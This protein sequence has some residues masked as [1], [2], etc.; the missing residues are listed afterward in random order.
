MSKNQ[1]I[2]GDFE[3]AYEPEPTQSVF[4]KKGGT[5]EQFKAGA[6][7]ETYSSEVEVDL[8]LSRPKRKPAQ[9]EE[10]DKPVLGKFTLNSFLNSLSANDG[11]R[12]I[13]EEEEDSSQNMPEG[14]NEKIIAHLKLVKFG[15]EV[16][17]EPQGLEGMDLQSYL[18][19][20]RP[21][22]AKAE[23]KYKTQEEKDL[24]QDFKQNYG[25]GFKMLENMGFKVTKGLGKEESGIQRPVEAVI[26]TAFTMKDE[27]P[28]KKANEQEDSEKE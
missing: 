5:Y 1:Q 23:P 11:L 8:P 6:T 16:E 20:N 21:R 7:I 17:E 12:E 2:Y 18:K 9:D 13:V 24:A 25:V 3:Y 14:L 10:E 27:V 26:K 15:E 22:V 28:Q 19:L 4:S